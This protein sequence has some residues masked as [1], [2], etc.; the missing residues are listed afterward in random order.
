M[1]LKK[2][3]ILKNLSVDC[4]VFGFQN[5]HLQVLLINLNVEPAKGQ[6]ALPGGNVFINEDLDQSAAR[7]LEEL[8]GVKNIYMEQVAAF[9]EIDRYPEVRIITISYCA[10]IKPERFKL[11][12][13]TQTSEVKWFRLKDIPPLAYDHNKI[14]NQALKQLKKNIRYRPIGFELLPKKFTLTDL[15][16]LYE[17]ILERQLDKRNFRKKILSMTLLK[18]L[19]EKKTGVAHRRPHLY[20]FDKKNYEMLK[21]KGF[22]F[23]L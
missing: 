21:Q 4:V 22:N 13:G 17:S 7:V 3:E 16:T 15:Q 6:W 11:S 18:K 2:T 12:P 8:T 9:G 14:L 23:E 10:L 1:I 5:P 20:R 19:G